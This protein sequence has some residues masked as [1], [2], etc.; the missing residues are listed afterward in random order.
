MGNSKAHVEQNI[1]AVFRT[2]GR[3]IG[4]QFSEALTTRPCRKVLR[5][6]KIDA[7]KPTVIATPQNFVWRGLAF[8]HQFDA[9][10]TS[11][12]QNYTAG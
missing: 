5:Q 9:D 11:L 8:T 1:I 6:T 4:S 10:A 7:M 3:L 2:K 12:R